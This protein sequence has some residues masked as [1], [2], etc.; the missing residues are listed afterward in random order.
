MY[1]KQA[2]KLC[3]QTASNVSLSFLSSLEISV[4]YLCM[5]FT[6][7]EIGFESAGNLKSHYDSEF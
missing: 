6:N 3:T 1:L 2:T 5:C 4:S 7:N